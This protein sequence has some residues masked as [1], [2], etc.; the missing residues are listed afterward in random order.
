[1]YY[2]G[3][4]L[5]SSLH[6]KGNE[7]RKEELEQLQFNH[8]LVQVLSLHTHRKLKKDIGTALASVGND[9]PPDLR[10]QLLSQ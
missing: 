4:T 10:Q 5:L 8:S 3:T 1:M 2:L 7:P 6:D 9:V